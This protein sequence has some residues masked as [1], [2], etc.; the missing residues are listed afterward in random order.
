MFVLI[1]GLVLFL[2]IHSVRVVA[3][4]WRGAQIERLGEGPWKGI[5]SLVSF[6]GLGLIVLGYWL[7][8]E[9]A[10]VFYEQ[11]VWIRSFTLIVMPIVLI[12]FFAGVFRAGYIKRS[13]KHPMLIGTVLWSAIHLI[14]NGD[15]A[16]ILL[17]VGFFVWALIDLVSVFRRPYEAPA[18]TVLWPDAVSIALGLFV[19]WLLVMWLHGWLFGVALL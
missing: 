15:L 18:E 10:P 16:S 2:G 14:G 4:A 1:A 3:P 9:E 13:I 12:I 17:F 5:Y 11:A 19:T 6:A 7:A 8:R